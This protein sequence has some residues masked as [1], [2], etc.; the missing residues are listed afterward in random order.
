M[1][2]WHV[3]RIELDSFVY[4]RKKCFSSDETKH[5]EPTKDWSQLI[6]SS[7]VG[8]LQINYSYS[9]VNRVDIS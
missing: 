5:L 1:I 7:S 8:A 4:A 9:G 6:A 3:K 2:S